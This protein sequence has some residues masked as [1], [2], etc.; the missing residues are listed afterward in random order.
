MAAALLRR[1]RSP[2]RVARITAVPL[3]MV[4]LLAQEQTQWG[5]APGRSGAPGWVP[6]WVSI[7]TGV[8]ALLDIAVTVAATVM[9]VTVLAW[10]SLL[11][12]APLLALLMLATI[13]RRA[14]RAAEATRD[15][16]RWPR[17]GGGRDGGR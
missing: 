7:T 5:T 2:A 16:D 1:G 6:V 4:V 14:A 11:A 12:A 10:L 17:N 3:A 13:A 8:S 9:H 15:R